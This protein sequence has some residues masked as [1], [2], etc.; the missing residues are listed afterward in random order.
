MLIFRNTDKKFELQGDLL[1]MISNKNYNV[2]L[3]KLLDKKIVLDF[4]RE[5]YSDERAPEKNSM[6]E[7]SHIWLVKPPANMVFGTSTTFLPENPNGLRDR[8]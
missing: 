7:R 1:K 3:A 5:I 6:K 2:D 4:A 8:I